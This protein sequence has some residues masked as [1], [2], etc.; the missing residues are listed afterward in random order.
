MINEEIIQEINACLQGR[1]TEEQR[2]SVAAW[3]EGHVEHQQEYKEYCEVYYKLTYAA[4]W[5][6]I[7]GKGAKDRVYRRI[8]GRKRGLALGYAVSGVAAIFVL[9]FAVTLLLKP[10]GVEQEETLALALVK[11]GEKKAVLTLADGRKMELSSGNVM[12]DLGGAVA[13]GD[14]ETGLSY[15]L[16]DSTQI[17]LE[18]NTLNV[19]RGGEYRLALSDGTRVWLNSETELKY[20]VVFSAGSREVYVSGEA[21]FEVTKD[22]DRLFIVHT[23]V[24]KT[25]V[26]G[27][28]FNV[29][30][31]KEEGMSEITLLRGLV[32]VEAGN[33]LKRIT[34]G[35]QVSVD[36]Q[37]RSVTER[38]VNVAFYSSWKD[39]LFDFEG[40][41]LEE[42]VV[43]LGRWYDVDFFFVNK[44][45]R[46]KKFT[47]AVK[48]N[49]T[50]EFMLNFVEKTSDVRFSIKGKTVSVYNK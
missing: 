5:P 1:A 41:T 16:N 24:T 32:D 50:L 18:Y 14:D 27:T 40:M 46:E 42:L 6:L 3:L 11:S 28:S 31:Y 21:F 47:G 35:R 33:V 4:Q 23:A 25:I 22:P 26:R 29:M 19:P 7:N 13:V 43:K 34:P 10:S 2:Q 9:F 36:N 49:N 15:R 12:V 39:G 44:E 30:A 48:R 20:P 17:G 8:A 37:S 45:A 38:E